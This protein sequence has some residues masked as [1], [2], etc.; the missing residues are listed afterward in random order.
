M[1]SHKVKFK[2][3]FSI[4]IFTLCFV[5]ISAEAYYYLDISKNGTAYTEE[6][7][8]IKDE[9][10]G[11]LHLNG[12]WVNYVF[13]VS[14]WYPWITT[15]DIRVGVYHSDADKNEAV[16]GHVWAT[17][18]VKKKNQD[19]YDDLDDLTDDDDTPSTEYDYFS[20]GSYV[21]SKDGAYIVTIR[22]YAKDG[23][24]DHAE[25]TIHDV[26]LRL[27]LDYAQYNMMQIVGSPKIV[28]FGTIDLGSTNIT[29]NVTIGNIGNGSDTKSWNV[30]SPSWINSKN[31]SVDP[32]K[33]GTIQLKI[34][35][36]NLGSGNIKDLGGKLVPV[37]STGL[38]ASKN[39]LKGDFYHVPDANLNNL[40]TALSHSNKKFV[41]SDIFSNIQFNKGTPTDAYT[42][43]E[44]F[45]SGTVT[46]TLR[47]DFVAVFTGFI[48]VNNSGSHRFFVTSDDGFRLKVDGIEVAKYLYG[49][50]TATTE[51]T[52]DLSPGYHSIEL[53]YFQG[54]GGKSLTLEWQQPSG[55]R[56][57]VSSGV[58]SNGLNILVKA[59]PKKP[60]VTITN[61]KGSNNRV[62]VAVGR[63][64]KFTAEGTN[65]STGVDITGFLWQ[66]VVDNQEAGDTYEKTTQGEKK[67]HFQ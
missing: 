27:P 40:D 52:K 28:D 50:G 17:M 20:K 61:E 9:G 45:K 8:R 31:G 10:S 13:D 7:G 33:T 62:N 2:I 25:A 63:S 22:I 23:I 24:T 30:N 21:E 26:G 34:N 29:Q 32:Y 65:G 35:P 12:G 47:R 53:T 1:L 56:E 11:K 55:S 14:E 4:L 36:N 44:A 41:F 48:K 46:T 57:I 38:D 39:G 66:K 19:T 16:K 15:S 37:S 60:S 49:R 67:L 6:D 64:A 5:S 3:L 58:L 43:N 42:E 18:Q 51:G 54:S 59:T